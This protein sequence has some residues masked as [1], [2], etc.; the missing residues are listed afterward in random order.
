MG[1][2]FLP[3]IRFPRSNVL[4]PP[5]NFILSINGSSD[6]RDLPQLGR[7]NNARVYQVVAA[8]HN[9]LDSRRARELAVI[10][11]FTEEPQ[12]LDSLTYR[13]FDRSGTLDRQLQIDM[14]TFSFTLTTNYL[15]N[16]DFLKGAGNSKQLPSRTVAVNEVRDFLSLGRML[17]PE[18]ATAQTQV[19]YVRA[20]GAVVERVNTFYESDFL[21]VNLPRPP[22]EGRYRFWG[23]NNQSSVFAVVARDI[24]GQDH[25]VHLEYFYHQINTSNFETYPLRSTADAFETLQMGGG[26]IAAM[27]ASSQVIIDSVQLGYYEDPHDGGFLQP[28]F[29]FTSRDGFVGYVQAVD[30]RAIRW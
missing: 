18:L 7:D 20:V 26:H 8:A 30:P 11:G 2:G 27:G 19:E 24:F 13:F 22:L 15:T 12:A 16:P 25:I 3:P 6:P 28:I 1:Y 4:H 21:S 17:P 23:P 10:Y 29:V 14:R 5:T 9:L